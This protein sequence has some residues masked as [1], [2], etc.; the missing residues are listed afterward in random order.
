[1]RATTCC[2][3]CSSSNASGLLQKAGSAYKGRARCNE[4]TGP[5]PLNTTD[6]DVGSAWRVWSRPSAF[7]RHALVFCVALRLL[8]ET[9]AQAWAQGVPPV[10]VVFVHG[11]YENAS[12]DDWTD[13]DPAHDA[14]VVRFNADTPFGRRAYSGV[15]DGTYMRKTVRDAYWRRGKGRSLSEIVEKRVGRGGV[16]YVR[17]DARDAWYFE[18]GA[19]PLVA[20]QVRAW[21]EADPRRAPAARNLVWVAHSN[22]GLIARALMSDPQYADLVARTREVIT[23]GTPHRGSEMA[24]A[25]LD[26]DRV[27]TIAD[28]LVAADATIGQTARFF[29]Q[30]FAIFDMAEAMLQPYLAQLRANIEAQAKAEGW[31]TRERLRQRRQAQATFLAQV[32]EHELSGRID[33]QLTTAFMEAAQLPDAEHRL[34][35]APELPVPFFWVRGTLYPMDV[36][37]MAG[38]A[39]QV[40]RWD[41]DDL[42]FFATSAA[43]VSPRLATRFPDHPQW[44][45]SD[46]VVSVESAAALGL[47]LEGDAGKASVAA[48]HSDLPFDRGL[49]ALLDRHLQRLQAEP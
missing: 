7:L 28:A 20:A 4:K 21:L 18:P 23:L 41:D 6:T 14:A 38:G 31:K 36:L 13:D 42:V 24:D 27:K 45:R 43:I 12:G 5:L 2:R 40:G 32:Y 17:Y 35:P 29:G 44:Q 16:L 10:L 3:R 49:C 34:L 39:L 9:A 1:M 22:G 30:R 48:H 26:G 8:V 15:S 47:P 19:A 25:G 33:A 11:R 37:Q 46:G